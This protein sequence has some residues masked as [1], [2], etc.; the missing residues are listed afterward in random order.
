MGKCLYLDRSCTSA[1]K[2]TAVNS[3]IP[4]IDVNIS[5]QGVCFA[6]FIIINGLEIFLNCFLR[7][8]IINKKE[9]IRQLAALRYRYPFYPETEV[10]Q[11]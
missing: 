11:I 10:L 7:V 6:N 8:L 5:N 4:L 2:S 1:I 3:E 9:S